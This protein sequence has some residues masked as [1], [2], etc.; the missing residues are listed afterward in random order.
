MAGRRGGKTLSAAWELLYYLLH[1]E[2]H[3]R[4]AHQQDSDRPLV[5]WVL[6]KDY[7]SGLPA[8]LTFRQVLQE[9]GLQHGVEYKENKGNR[10]FEFENGSWLFFKT[11]D[12]PNS[13]RGAGLDFLWMDEASFIPNEDA[14]M[15]VRP[16][17]ADRLGSVL[18]TTTPDYKNWF[19]DEFWGEKALT[20]DRIGRVEYWSI[21]NPY[22]NEEEWQY[23]K[24]NTHPLI[25]R[26]EYCADWNAMAGRELA[27]EW[28]KYW[29]YKA[30]P[31]ADIITLPRDSDGKLKPLRFYIGVDPAISLNDKADHFAMA[32]VA[33]TE[34]HSQAFLYDT[35]RDHIPFPEQLDKIAEWHAKYHP[36]YI[37]VEAVAYQAALAQQALRLPGLP[38]VI[39]MFAKGKKFERILAM[40][41]LFKTGRI[42]IKKEHSDFIDEW[43]DYDSE[44]RNPKDDLLD[45]VEIAL[46]TAGALLPGMPSSTPDLPWTEDDMP[47]GSLEMLALRDRPGHRR[48]NAPWDEHLGTNF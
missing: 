26:R 9:A 36:Q 45:A 38:N 46:R 27:G 12:D 6:T 43:L 19:Y 33:V 4:D 35:Y 31:A 40:A 17:L 25:F 42:R 28:L 21:D 24:E 44:L 47:A 3:H 14:W 16:A 48:R 32:C 8:L 20:D 29:G 39:N 10:W 23:V 5:A 41:P 7:P 2:R 15:V 37:G 13:L 18:A 34:D 22:F 30:D 11:A 1:P